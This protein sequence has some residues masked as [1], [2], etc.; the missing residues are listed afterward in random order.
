MEETGPQEL[1]LLLDLFDEEQRELE[2]AI[3][4]YYHCPNKDTE[5][6]L[7][8]ELF[9]T[10]WTGIAWLKAKGYDP[11]EVWEEGSRSN[12]SKLPF[13][14]NDYG[15]VVKGPNYRKPVFKKCS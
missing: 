10:M 11:D 15:K 3:T 7:I 9:D 6:E 8:K 13:T 2:K 5:Y 14:Y 12:F 1:D 4:E